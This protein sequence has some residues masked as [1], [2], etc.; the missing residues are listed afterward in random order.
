[1]SSN[2]INVR[3]SSGRYS[4]EETVEILKSV[5]GRAGCQGCYSGL[6][7]NFVHELD[8]SVNARG[9]IAEGPAPSVA[10]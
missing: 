9:V 10:D 1:M 3:L 6:D 8:F 7:I 2:Q 5:L 4:F